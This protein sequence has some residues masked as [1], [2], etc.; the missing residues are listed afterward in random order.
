MQDKLNITAI[1]LTYNEGI[2]LQRCI[3]SIKNLV[4]D[5][6]VIDSSSTDRT[7]K[8]AMANNTRFYTHGFINYS[9]KFNWALENCNITTDWIWRIDADEYISENLASKIRETLPNINSGV[10]GIYVNRRIKFLGRTLRYGGWYPSWQ[11]KLVRFGFG[12]CE[13]RGL[14]EHFVLQTG[15]S[16][17]IKGDQVDYNLNNLTVWTQKHNGYSNKELAEQLKV[18]F[19]INNIENN[20]RPRLLGNQV[21]RK[22]WFKKKYAATPLFVRPFVLFFVKYFLQLGFLDGKAGF[23]WHVLQGFWY[24]FLVD[25]K[26]FELKRQFNNNQDEIV[27]YIKQEYSI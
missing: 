23:I 12:H 16:I 2:H 7:K 9:E 15:E 19:D 24:R 1:I 11:M 3:D 18:Q 13:N 17:K 27:K 6:C 14:D 20:I 8:I 10:N 26:I 5:I 4:Q 21:E 22:R 25:A